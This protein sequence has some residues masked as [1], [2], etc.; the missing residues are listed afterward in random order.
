MEFLNPS[1]MI[2]YA[3]PAF[4]SLML[5]E[6]LYGIFRKK[7]TYRFNDTFCSLTLGVLSRIPP[8]LHLGISGFVFGIATDH[9]NI[10]LLSSQNWLTWV[11]AFFIYDFLYYWKHRL[12]HERSMLWASHVVHH[13]SEDFNLGTALRQTSSGF[14]LNWIFFIPIFI[15]GIPVEVFISVADVNLIY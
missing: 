13:Q 6:F 4:L 14:L 1:L 7:N 2:L 12:S 15:L 5:L 11:I 10:E 8:A 3:L 9:F